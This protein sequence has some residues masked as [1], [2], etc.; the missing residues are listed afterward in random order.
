[1]PTRINLTNDLTETTS[2]L[3]TGSGAGNP[4][5]ALAIAREARSRGD[6]N[7]DVLEDTANYRKEAYLGDPDEDLESVSEEHAQEMVIED[8]LAATLQ[9]DGG[10][11][12][13]G[14]NLSTVMEISVISAT[15]T[16]WTVLATLGKGANATPYRV[17]RESIRI[18]GNG[19]QALLTDMD[20]ESQTF[21][22]ELERK[23]MRTETIRPK[24]CVI[25]DNS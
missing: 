22:F 18:V 12:L 24:L 2:F 19:Y 25:A 20:G 1:M 10:R 21:E 13:K 11:L 16:D 7:P 17:E 6:G 3:V 9:S 23:V 8:F 15:K 4:D 5:Q 14:W